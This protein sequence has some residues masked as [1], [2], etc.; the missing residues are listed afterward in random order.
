MKIY[1]CIRVY[2]YTS[3]LFE[4]ALF[5]LN[6]IKNNCGGDHTLPTNCSASLITINLFPKYVLVVIY[7]EMKQKNNGQRYFLH[8]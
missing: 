4:R 6:K 7:N 3:F 5:T 1:I 8:R 2:S